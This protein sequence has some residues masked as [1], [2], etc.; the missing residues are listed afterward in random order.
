MTEINKISVD[1]INWQAKNMNI[2][3]TECILREII[4]QA[5]LLNRKRFIFRDLIVNLKVNDQ[6]FKIPVKAKSLS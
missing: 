3:K 4:R 6:Q 1:E 2:E 5:R